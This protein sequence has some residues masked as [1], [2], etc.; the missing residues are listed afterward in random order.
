MA[1]VVHSRR[2]VR[3][4]AGPGAG[5]LR[6]VNGDLTRLIERSA[7]CVT[8]DRARSVIR[9]EAWEYAVRSG[10][11]RRVFPGTYIP[12]DVQ[13]TPELRRRAAVAYT[14]GRAA[15]SHLSAL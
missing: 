10:Q 13:L 11:L 1:V 12:A 6:T 5:S 9:A 8:V 15:L 7:G 2:R 3:G 4:T 14:G